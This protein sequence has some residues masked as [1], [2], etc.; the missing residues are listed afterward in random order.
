MSAITLDLNTR[1]KLNGL[2]Q[3]LEILDENGRLLGHFLPP[4]HYRKLVLAAA[5]SLC[6]FSETDLE[7]LRVETGGESL[8]DFWTRLENQ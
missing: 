6:P 3:P 2:S 7:R 5:E 1:E 8:R 4:A